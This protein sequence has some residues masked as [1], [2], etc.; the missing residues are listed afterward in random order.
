MSD[1]VV[2]AVHKH[3]G[4]TTALD[5]VSLESGPGVTALL[6]PNGAGK[7]T[8][9]RIMATVLWPDRGDVRVLGLD[10]AKGSERLEIRRRLGYMPQEPSFYL[11]FT[12]FEFV[13]YVAILKEMTNPRRRRAAVRG[14]LSAVGLD[15][16]RNRKIKALSGGMRRRVALAQSLL[17]DPEVLILDEPTVGLDPEQRLRFRE[18]ISGV[19]SHRAVVLSTHLTEDVSALS[20]HVVVIH[21][22]TSLFDGTPD[23]L[24]RLASGRVWLAERKEPGAVLAWRTGEGRYRNIGTAPDGAELV[25]PTIEDGYLLLVGDDLLGGA[26]R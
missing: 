7:T 3:Y 23:G 4:K 6:G 15:A 17:G 13:E 19:A 24:A 21:R 26:P 2:S 9:L 14:V 8:L 10:P 16:L 25:T 22:G 5:G 1:L 18:L 20:G 11:D 12:A